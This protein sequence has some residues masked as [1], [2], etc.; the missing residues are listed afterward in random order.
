MNVNVRNAFDPIF[1]IM[2]SSPSSTILCGIVIFAIEFLQK[3]INTVAKECMPSVPEKISIQ[4]PS[5]KA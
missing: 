5:K 3:A 2:S 1:C 4:N